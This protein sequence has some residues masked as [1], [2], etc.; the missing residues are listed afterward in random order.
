MVWTDWHQ[1]IEG[2]VLVGTKFVAF[3]CYNLRTEIN[4]RWYGSSGSVD[5]IMRGADA[6]KVYVEEIWD[7]NVG[8]QW[9]YRN[10]VVQVHRDVLRRG[11]GDLA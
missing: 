9:F 8:R 5:L 1:T 2:L 6:V 3:L 10:S 11:S 7:N 4:W